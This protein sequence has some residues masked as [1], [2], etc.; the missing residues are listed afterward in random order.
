MKSPFFRLFGIPSK[1][2]KIEARQD[3]QGIPRVW[4]RP[5]GNSPVGL[6]LTSANELRQLLTDFG[7]LK[8]ANEIGRHI[9]QAE[10]LT[11]HGE[12]ASG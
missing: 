6:N 9:I 8:Q 4:F 7:K 10:Q 3:E 5:S 12:N 11:S 1:E 2:F